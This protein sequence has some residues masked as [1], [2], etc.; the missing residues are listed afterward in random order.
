MAR[1]TRCAK[2]IKQHI[3]IIVY[4]HKPSLNTSGIS[5]IVQVGSVLLYNKGS[6]KPLS[7]VLSGHDHCCN[8][9]LSTH[10]RMGWGLLHITQVCVMA[11]GN[12]Q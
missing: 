9:H 2:G 3:D 12:L 7:V 6:P 11:Q 10:L 5:A 4:S 1:A 8:L